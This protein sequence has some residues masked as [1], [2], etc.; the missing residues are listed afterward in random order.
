[1]QRPVHFEIPS[2]DP[3]TAMKFWT[4]VFG[5]KFSKWGEM[6]YWLVTTGEEG[7]VGINGGLMPRR[8]PA[9]PVVNTMDVENIDAHAE[10]VT[11]AGG[12]IVVPKM[13]IPTVGWLAYFKDPD[14]NIWGLMQPDPSAA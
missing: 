8:D 10:K 7:S 11:A 14:G 6:D 5:W 2:G 12:Q 4:D 13:A 1:M 9:Q 3:E